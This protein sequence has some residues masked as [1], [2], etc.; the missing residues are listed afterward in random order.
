MKYL[1]IFRIAIVLAAMSLLSACANSSVMPAEEKS[2]TKV[3]GSEAMRPGSSTECPSQD[4]MEFLQSYA[5]SEDDG[6]RRRYT[7]D[8]LA[9]EVPYHTV[10]EETETTPEMDISMKAG[11]KRIDY[12][13]YRYFRWAN[14]FDSPDAADDPVAVQAMKDGN[15]RYPITISFEP[16]GDHKVVVGQEYEVDI[17]EFK[18]SR[19]CW[20][21]TRVINPRD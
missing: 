17:Y 13:R 15:R 8:P 21:L 19:S 3:A 20:Y 14:A 11:D 4:F 9:Y 5:D 10:R 1:S 7:S 12:F 6:I 18:R 16:N 2:K